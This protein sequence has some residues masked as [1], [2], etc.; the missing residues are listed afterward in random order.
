VTDRPQ[1]A[2]LRS[3]GE[4]S[5]RGLAEHLAPVDLR[6]G[7]K[8][9]DAERSVEWVHFPETCLLSI[10]TRDEDGG[11]VETTMVGAE[12]ALMLLEACG[13]GTSSADC[14]IQIDGRAWRAPAATCRTAMLSDPDFAKCALALFELQTIESRQSGLCQGLHSVEPRF[15]RWLLEAHERADG[16]N[17]MP[18]T[19]EFIAA[20]LGVRRTTVTVF[21]V[22][23]QKAG[24]IGYARG[25][26]ELLDLE[27]LEARACS[28]RQVTR[29]HRRRLWL[30]PARGERAAARRRAA[31][32]P[33]S[34][35][36]GP[37]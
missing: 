24:L 32:P 36:D 4:E 16:R 15:A 37:P 19:Q 34:L 25:R 1:N 20:M 27:G 13:S 30:E 29:E 2:F 11:T 9:Q 23:L 12:G 33:P 8:L 6:L 5:Y 3:L 22:Q 7:Q 35:S 21:A 28:C 31:P 17:P 26:V 18:L 14:F 10:L